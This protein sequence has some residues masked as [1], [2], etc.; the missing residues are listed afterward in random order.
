MKSNLQTTTWDNSYIYKNFKDPKI[1]QDLQFIYDKITYL[2]LKMPTLEKWIPDIE[3]TPLE[4][5]QETIPLARELYRLGLD[6]QITLWTLGTYAGCAASVD[7]QDIEAKGLSNE[8]SQLSATLE[9][10]TKPLEIFL[11]RSP[12]A[13]LNSFLQDEQVQEGRFPLLHAK[14]NQ[15][16]MLSVSEEVLLEGHSVDGFHAWGRLYNELSGTMKIDIEGD[17]MG[18]AVA[19]NLIYGADRKKRETA[20]RAINKAWQQNETSASA[21]LNSLSGWRLEN[22]KARSK[23]QP[24]HFLDKTCHEQKVTRETLAAMMDATYQ[25]R[26]IGHT[27]LKLMAESMDISGPLAPWDL[28][29]A[30]PSK[31]KAE[32]I[33]F[34]E[35]MTLIIDAFNQFDP[36]LGAFAKMMIDKKWIDSTPTPNRRSGAY[37]TGFASQREPRVF[38]TYDGNM[39][40][41][42][43]LAHELGHAYHGWVMRDLK[44][45]ECDYPSTLAETASLFAEN[46]VRDS[47]LE[48]AKSAENK[49]AILWQEVE[50]AASL[51]INIPARFEFEKRL[52]EL[53]QTK[54]VT[55][56]DLKE[57]TRESWKHWY[58]DTLNEYNE[59]F[60]ASKLHFSISQISF[61][62]Y[63]YI[64][65]YLFSLGIYAQKDSAGTAFNTKYNNLLRDT[66]IMTAE[67]LVMKHLKEDI[68]QKDFWKKSLNIVE[69]SIN[70][71]KAL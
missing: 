55:A 25:N 60:W 36:D 26:H 69:N 3:K 1:K 11:T 41:I 33:P 58:G 37:C 54:M 29:A 30:Y 57:I 52:M 46:L 18:L 21:I 51:L 45:L 12:L 68:T 32:A 35:G 28:L 59:M 61:Y 50:S 16:Y 65:G 71:F 6:L 22:Y 9:K 64:F 4:N 17:S 56:A 27:A 31:Q 40:N 44:Y 15:P 13:Y 19:T 38:I 2:N 42:I 43:T 7:T 70:K 5:L 49:K 48:N 47:I 39:K 67:D 10:A 20:Y 34:P 53:R 62:N 24:M 63:P 8:T 23:K 66:G 14:K